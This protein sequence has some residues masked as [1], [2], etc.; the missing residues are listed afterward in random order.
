MNLKIQS[1]ALVFNKPQYEFSRAAIKTFQSH[2]SLREGNFHIQGQLGQIS[3]SDQSPH[4]FKFRERFITT[5]SQAM[6]FD[7]LKWV[8]SASLMRSVLLNIYFH[9]LKIKWK[10]FCCKCRSIRNA[11]L[12]NL[13]WTSLQCLQN[14]ISQ[15]QKCI[16]LF[17]EVEYWLKLFN[18]QY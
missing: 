14:S 13:F 6:D 7:V 10:H 2:V 17:Y 1:F 16:F 4:G 18:V 15:R 9:E 12:N 5:G 3:L 11:F 8:L